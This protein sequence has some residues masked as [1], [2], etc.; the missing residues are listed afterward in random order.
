MHP[1]DIIQEILQLIFWLLVSVEPDRIRLGPM[2]LDRKFSIDGLLTVLTLVGSV[3][4]FIVVWWLNESQKKAVNEREYADKIRASASMICAKL[5]RW[6]ELNLNFFYQ[7]DNL[8]ETIDRN[9]AEDQDFFEA[10]TSLYKGLVEARAE[11]NMKIL[12]EEIENAYKDLYGYAPGREIFRD[13]INKF[14]YIDRRIHQVL[15]QLTENDIVHME[16]LLETGYWKYADVKNP[17]DQNYLGNRLRMTAGMIRFLYTDLMDRAIGPFKDT[18]IELIG[19]EDQEIFATANK[20]VKKILYNIHDNIYSINAP[21]LENRIF[22]ILKNKSKVD[23]FPDLR[24][25]YA[26]YLALRGLDKLYSRS[27]PEALDYYSQATVLSPMVSGFWAGKCLSLQAQDRDSE[28]NDPFNKA[29]ELIPG[30]PN[31]KSFRSLLNT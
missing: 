23:N 4:S 30:A 7:I 13:T 5:D 20:K 22:E 28:A 19:K 26:N 8:I 21:G 25:D 9:L 27:Y 18:M 29:K 1:Q 10:K 14:K 12:D 31:A 6:K 3:L 16:R 24:D 17:F 2:Y 11:V 15:L